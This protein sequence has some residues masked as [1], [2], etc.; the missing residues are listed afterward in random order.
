[1]FS[2]LDVKVKPNRNSS[3]DGV[4]GSTYM[5]N[6]KELDLGVFYLNKSRQI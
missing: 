6:T 5:A 2:P 4:S 3:V 1:M